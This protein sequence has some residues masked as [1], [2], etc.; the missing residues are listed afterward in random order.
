MRGSQQNKPDCQKKTKKNR[1]W[2]YIRVRRRFP[3]R[4]TPKKQKCVFYPAEDATPTPSSIGHAL[5]GGSRYGFLQRQ[6]GLFF[7]RSWNGGR[8]VYL[9]SFFLLGW[10]S[11]FPLVKAEN[12]WWSAGSPGEIQNLGSTLKL[13]GIAGHPRSKN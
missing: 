10:Y 9:E 11:V 4:Q 6:Q 5:F 2:R 8:P 12:W 13:S 3:K 1:S 7:R